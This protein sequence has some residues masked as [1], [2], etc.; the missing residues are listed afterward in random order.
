M[1]SMHE[2]LALLKSLGF[3]GLSLVKAEE[4]KKTYT[5]KFE[6]F[7]PNIMPVKPTMAADGKV[8]VF[9]IPEVGKI[10]VSKANRILRF[11]DAGLRKGQ[12]KVDDSHITK[13][14]LP[15]ELEDLYKKAVVSSTQRLPFMKK[16]WHFF[17]STKFGG[18]MT[19]P[20]LEAGPK[21]SFGGIKP[22]QTRGCYY[23]DPHF[24]P[25]RLWMNPS[26]FNGRIHFFYE[27]YLHEMCHQAKW[28]VSKDTDTKLK[29][30]GKT[31]Q[32][33]MVHVGLDPRRY[34]PTDDYEYSD[35]ATK[36]F[37]EASLTEKYGPRAPEQKIKA[38][39]K[40]TQFVPGPA[41][42]VFKG[43]IFDGDLQR[44]EH[45][46]RFKYLDPVKGEPMR[47]VWPNMSNFLRVGLPSFFH[48][49]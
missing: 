49:D 36:V 13:T 44:T 23:G 8:V 41:I 28:T 37:E 1:L 35:P 42:Y 10:G 21:P 4:L 18:Q 7:S 30:H 20:R 3:T 39:R 45:D 40:M 19:E 22:G 11:V 48:K 31:W 15:P 14:D 2:I 16:L 32:K 29:G 26:M 33:W 17:N 6:H 24:G 38:L 34:D 12:P 46:I 47:M 43:R 25:G 9:I 5:F 27:I